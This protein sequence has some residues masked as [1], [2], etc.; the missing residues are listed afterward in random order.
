MLKEIIDVVRTKNF[1]EN[2][3]FLPTDAHTYVYVSGGK[4]RSFLENF[5]YVL[6]KW[7]QRE[8]KNIKCICFGDNG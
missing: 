7:Y 3:H 2:Y 5:V 4:K 1:P 8:S 6:N